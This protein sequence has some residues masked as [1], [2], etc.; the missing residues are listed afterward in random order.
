MRI[1]IHV[2]HEA[3]QKIGGIGAVLSGLCTTEYYKQQY[4]QTLFYGPL[5]NDDPNNPQRLG[6]H[7][8]ILYSTLDN[9]NRTPM[10]P[11]LTQLS[12]QQRVDIVY[13]KRR[14]FDDI[15]PD[16]DIEVDILLV[17]I[18]GMSP[19]TID[20]FKFRLWE[21][22]KLDS[23]PFEMDWD[24]EQYLRIG[25]IIHEIIAIRYPSYEEMHCF[26]HEYMGVASCLSLLIHKVPNL[27]T[28]F[29]AHEVST[30][31]SI[32]EKLPG[33]DV[34]FY[35]HMEKD[36]S[37]HA[38]LE[39]R[40]G[41][42][43]NNPRHALIQLAT[44]FDEI[45]AVGD[46]V[47]SE[48]QYIQP[49]VKPEHIKITYN[50]IPVKKVLWEEKK[51]SR[52]LL[53]TYCKTLYNYE[54]D[55]LFTHVTRLV[56]SKGL[57]RDLV[58]L[59]EIDKHFAQLGYKGF[60]ILLSTLIGTGRDPRD[61]A[62][63]EQKYGWPVL[64]KQGW[65]DLTGAEIE[66]FEQLQIFNAKSKAIKGV[67]INQYNFNRQKCGS[68]MP[69]D[70]SFAD[71]RIGSDAE[72]GLSVYEPFG[73]AQI[74]TVP[75]GGIAIVSRACGCSFLLEKAFAESN[76][77]PYTILDF[78]SSYK[79]ANIT[80][81]LS[82][83]ERDAFEEKVIQESISSLIERLP[84]KESERQEMF[85]YCQENSYRLGWDYLVRTFL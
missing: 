41:K 52:E 73:I 69:K 46:W 45:F 51:K 70:M 82:E 58:L 62:Y 29:Y 79:Q 56:T 48:F 13:G 32:V 12:S 64:H 4:Q 66:I 80:H 78:S 47:K 74:E 30:V 3:A 40:Y 85:I 67:F 53:Q 7:S 71:I 57:W 27:K 44:H 15:Y 23:Q 19:K 72:I 43:I 20:V 16:K 25:A 75:Y 61:I 11:A 60:Y 2:T 33:L 36:L 49:Q 17:G 55:V 50:G 39:K 10:S 35:P 14:I 6:E 37:T 54:P 26:S 21:S 1:A 81:S 38:R 59:E 65:P 31:R 18:K 42:Q 68:R 28:V 76:C 22:Y 5:F 63:M 84:F 8:T 34:E 24:Y 9:I 83:N 77:K